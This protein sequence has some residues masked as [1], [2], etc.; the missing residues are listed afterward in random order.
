MSWVH[1]SE[2]IWEGGWGG[3]GWDKA[4]PW[5]PLRNELG[6]SWGCTLTRCK[7]EGGRGQVWQGWTPIGAGGTDK[8]Q[9]LSGLL[10]YWAAL[11]PQAIRLHGSFFPAPALGGTLNAAA[12][13]RA[14]WVV[15]GY[16]TGRW[17]PPRPETKALPPAICVISGPNFLLWASASLYKIKGLD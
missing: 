13:R 6:L 12:D 9:D 11:S 7:G 14:A 4:S 3:L 1:L 15:R 10:V 2:R 8:H 17:G 16:R 5:G